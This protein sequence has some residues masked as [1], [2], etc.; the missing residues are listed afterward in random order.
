MPLISCFHPQNYLHRCRQIIG[1]P[2]RHASRHVALK[3]GLH[4]NAAHACVVSALDVDLG[5]AN[6]KRTRK[7]DLVSSRGLDD[8]AGRG[9]ATRGILAGNIWAEIS[10]IDQ[11][12]PKLAQNLGFNSAILLDCKEAAADAALVRDDDE[13]EPIRFQAPQCLQ[14]AGE[15]LHVLRIGTV[16]AIFHDRA[17][18]IDK[19]G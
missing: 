18:A 3:A 4:S 6:K 11:T 5:V 10:R 8:H 19:D 17:V 1:P 15:N 7:I 12:N 13:F 16:N 9:L 2:I 14:Y